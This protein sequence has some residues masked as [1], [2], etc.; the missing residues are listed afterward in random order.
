MVQ[1]IDGAVLQISERIVFRGARQ[2]MLAEYRLLKPGIGSI[3]RISRRLANN[4]VAALNRLATI[5]PG[6]SP[7]GVDHLTFNMKTPDEKIVSCVLQILEHRPRIL[8]HQNRVRWII[9]DAKL[10]TDSMPLTDAV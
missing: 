3:P 2:F 9:V 6:G 10:I 7:S 4:P 8:A 5:T 1:P